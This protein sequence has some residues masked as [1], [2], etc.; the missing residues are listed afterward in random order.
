M[1]D[2]EAKEP[3][4][5]GKASITEEDMSILLQRYPAP[6]VLTLLQEVANF[7]GA[8]IDWESL[9]R[10]SSTGISNAREYQML[11]RHL[12]YRDTLPE[13]MEDDAEPVNDDSDL[14]L[15]LE[16]SP[17]VSRE[18]SAEA[19][20][21]VKVLIASGLPSESTVS[22][23]LTVE[24]PLTINVLNGQ[25][26]KGRSEILQA[27]SSTHSLN[28]TVPVSVQK[29]PMPTVASSGGLDGN[30]PL[31]KKRKPWS[32]A[33]DLELIAAVQKCGEGNWANILKS[34]FKGDRTAS[35]LSQRWAIIRKRQKNLNVGA[36]SLTSTQLSEAQVA[37][38][39]AMSLALGRPERILTS[40]TGNK[41]AQNQ[42]QPAALMPPKPSPAVE[43]SS[44]VKSVVSIKRSPPKPSTDTDSTKITAAAVAAGA[45]I[46]TPLDAASLM[47]TAQAKKTVRVIPSGGSSVIKHTMS[48]G[49]AISGAFPN[50]HH[51]RTGLSSPPLSGQAASTS[52]ATRISLVKPASDTVHSGPVMNSQ[53]VDAKPVESTKPPLEQEAKCKNER[54]VFK[55]CNVPK[56]QSQ[57]HGVC[58]LDKHPS[59]QVEMATTPQAQAETREQV[60]VEK[61]AKEGE[62]LN[63]DKTAVCSDATGIGTQ[64]AAKKIPEEPSTDGKPG[65]DLPGL[66]VDKERAEEVQ[67]L[68]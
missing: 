46:A 28:I 54:E 60:N 55:P 35:Q 18:S 50:V 59:P 27:P 29:Q 36:G 5:N 57:E 12:A 42:S 13:K 64:P 56:D 1:T 38:N 9:V 66:A 2:F 39:R 62:S 63:P 68:R 32:K 43:S 45:R 11:W 17:A 8:K 19:A 20:A 37:A 33:E 52:S 53:Q 14:E 31:K 49:S 48:G 3:K 51:I 23:N 58:V 26:S 4:I 47:M 44:M 41:L 10:N 40:G 6:T 7:R 21:S 65:E 30:L 34:D 24:A 16:A 67:V 22:N 15:E 25:S 61:E